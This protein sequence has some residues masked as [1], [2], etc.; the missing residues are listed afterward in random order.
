MADY[1]YTLEIRLTPDQQSAVTRVQDVARAAGMNVY[2]TGGAVRDIISGFTIRDLDFTVQGNALKL[3]KELERGGAA[4]QSVDDDQ[5]ALYLTLPGNVRAEISMARTERYEKPGKPPVVT[6]GTILEDLRRRDFTVNAMALSL[7]PGSRGLLMDP[8]NGAADI[9]AKLIRALHN[10]A[11]VEDP[12]RLIRASRFAARFHWPLEERTQARFDSAKENKYIEY[13]TNKAIG[14]EI[15]QLAFED[16]P[17]HIIRVLEKDDW[18]KVLNP[19][20]TTAKVDSAG[21]A[22]LMKMRQQMN[23]LGYWP[24]P[25]PAVLYFLTARLGDKDIADL[26]KLIPRKDLVESWRDLEDN[27]KDLAKKLMGKEAATP[28][29]TWKVLSEARPEMVLFLSVTA[30]QQAVVQKI[31]NFFTKWRQVQ[32]KIP[33]PEMT[34]LNI[35]PQMAEYAKVAHAVSVLMVYGRVRSLTE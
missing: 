24:D 25:A 2:L 28:S 20:W 14:N 5:K 29:R 30:R 31:R 16:D 8:F 19:H 11:F 12:A 27:A 35:T 33:L 3:Q 10:Y 32:Q 17:L 18:L 9:E 6:P 4:T 13:I 15:A 21:L 7:N 22:Q 23:D 34:E 1:I 26:R